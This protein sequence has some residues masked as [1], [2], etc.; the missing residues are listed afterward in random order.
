VSLNSWLGGGTPAVPSAE[1]RAT[2]AWRRIS[3]CPTS[4]T[5]RRGSG[6]SKQTLAAQTVRV[7]WDNTA[8][9]RDG[10][11]TAAGTQHCVVFG[12]RDHATV[13]DTNIQRADRFGLDGD[14]YE[15]ITLLTPPGEVQA[16]CE[17]RT[18]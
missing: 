2:Q 8:I 15:V 4:I 13:T 1:D 14:E 7:E 16:V 18:T 12:V 9:E 10:Q 17:R 5:I 6:A 3:D 11:I